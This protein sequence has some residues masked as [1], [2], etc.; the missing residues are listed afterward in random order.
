MAEKT[1]PLGTGADAKVANIFKQR[2]S[3]M[4]L[5]LSDL[6]ERAKR[7]QLLGFAFAIK[8]VG[9]HRHRIGFAGAFWDDPVQAAGAGPSRHNG[10]TPAI[11]ASRAMAPDV[12]CWGPS[13]GIARGRD[14]ASKGPVQGQWRRHRSPSVL[15]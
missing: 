8:T 13:S 10:A 12:A 5:A 15:G 11:G 2:D 1:V 3:A 6:L 9:A 4:V 14:D 7:G